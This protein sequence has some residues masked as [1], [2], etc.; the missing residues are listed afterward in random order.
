MDSVNFVFLTHK[1]GLLKDKLSRVLKCYSAVCYLKD[2]SEA[3]CDGWES[4]PGQLLGRQL[5]SP[6]YHHR[7]ILPGLSSKICGQAPWTMNYFLEHWNLVAKCKFAGD[8]AINRFTIF[9]FIFND[10]VT[11]FGRGLQKHLK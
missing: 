4:N 9:H 6:L 1:L 3:T 8:P 2:T 5:C 10:D 11:A 7:C